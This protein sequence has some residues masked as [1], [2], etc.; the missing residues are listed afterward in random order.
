MPHYRQI[1]VL[2]GV[3]MIFSACTNYQGAKEDPAVFRHDI[4]GSALPFTHSNFDTGT[5]KFTFALFSDLT[6]GERDGVFEVA[7]EQLRLLRP[8]L[9]VNVGDLID[10]GTE[11]RVQLAR[12]WDSFDRRARRARA[13]VFYAGGNHDLTN[14]VMHEVWEQRY[15][16]S[17]Y[18]FIY[19]DVLFLVLDTEDNPPEM[20]QYI[21]EIRSEAIELYDSEG[22]E[23][24]LKTEYAQLEERKSGRIGVQQAA[25][26]RQVLAEYPDVRWTF[27]MMHKPA[28]ERPDEEHFSAIETALSGQPYTV[29]YGHL[30]SYLH[31][32]RHG[33]DYIRLGTTG[34]LHGA[35][36]PM[37][38]DHVTLVTVSGAGTDIANLRMSGI[39]DRTGKVPLNG[40]QICLEECRKQ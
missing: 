39:F 30:H 19:K 12:E 3:L 20:Q 36:D 37:A 16:R 38:I 24:Y 25:Y 34:G 22:L 9:I 10:G 4:E 40:D 31:Q 1:S 21:Y 23:A 18:H 26:F 6:G 27:L 35:G 17:Y 8:E 28:W 11:D 29:F 13:P 5:D 33:Q 32:Q 2:L 7:I 14:T 15:G